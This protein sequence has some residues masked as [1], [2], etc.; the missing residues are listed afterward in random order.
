MGAPRRPDLLGHL[1]NLLGG[2]ISPAQYWRWYI[3]AQ[4]DI[5]ASANDADLDLAWSVEHRFAEYTGGHID[6]ATL[7]AAIRADV[8]A[9]ATAAA[10]QS[11][12]QTVRVA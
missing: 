10:A 1:G 6:A 12:S 11:R 5:E 8:Q 4:P 3:E 2:S 9:Y 7:V